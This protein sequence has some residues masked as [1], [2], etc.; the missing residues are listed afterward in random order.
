MAK[1]LAL[2]ML[3]SSV[4]ESEGHPGW[5]RNVPIPRGGATTYY[6]GLYPDAL[7]NVLHEY[8]EIDKHH[9]EELHAI[10]EVKSTT[11]N[12]TIP[13]TTRDDDYDEDPFFHCLIHNND[14]DRRVVNVS[15]ESST[16][17]DQI[18]NDLFEKLHDKL[19]HHHTKDTVDDK[20]VTFGLREVFDECSKFE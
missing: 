16:G 11:T 7:T 17:S 15:S 14:D 5:F 3:L 8:A 10:H 20:K 18:D 12:K 19:F 2:A 13:P 1:L 6:P 4:P 9:D